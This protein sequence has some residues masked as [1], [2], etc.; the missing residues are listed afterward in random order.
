MRLKME[1]PQAA[2]RSLYQ[3]LAIGWIILSMTVIGFQDARAQLSINSLKITEIIT[4]DYPQ[5]LVRALLRDSNNQPVLTADVP[6]LE[7]IEKVQNKE[8]VY[9]NEAAGYTYQQVSVGVEVIFIVDLHSEMSQ[10]L[11]A[12]GM[13]WMEEARKIVADY[14]TGM[15]AGDTAGILIVDSSGP[16]YLRPITADT[17]ALAGAIAG[18]G[19][20]GISR[21]SGVEAV[22][23][24]LNDLEKSSAYRKV[25]QSVIYISTGPSEQ[26]FILDQVIVRSNELEI[27]VHTFL[28]RDFDYIEAVEPLEKIADGCDGTFTYF[29]NLSAAIPVYNWLSNQRSQTE[30]RYRSSFGELSERTVELRVPNGPSS[31]AKSYL[32]DLQPPLVIIDSPTNNSEFTRQAPRHDSVMDEVLPT[33]QQITAHVEWPDQHPRELVLAQFLLNGVPTDAS[34]SYPSG[35]LIFSWDLK[36]YRTRGNNDVTIQV[37]VQDE[38]GF[39]A[40]SQAV[41]AR[42]TVIIPDPPEAVQPIQG[43][44]IA[45][46]ACANLE[47]FALFWCQFTAQL[48]LMLTTP[49]GWISLGSMIVALAAIVLALRYREPILKAGGEAMDVIRTTF[50]GFGRHEG[51]QATG[52]IEVLRG[53]ADLVGKTIP[54]YPDTLTPI[55][56]SPQEAELVFDSHNERSVVSRRHCE[57]REED[58]VFRIRD[59]GSRH[60]TFVNSNR[61]EEGGDGLILRD[62]DKIELGPA[63]R[64][65][66]LLIFRTSPEKS[67]PPT[68]I[69]QPPPPEPEDDEDGFKTTPYYG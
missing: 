56:R 43:E 17:A 36:P 33:L 8:V 13:T 5:V 15:Q 4:T 6:Q 21:P 34:L 29:N 31:E 46:E 7:I 32:V 69:R 42:V 25:V 16:T 40:D 61:L 35:T 41:S 9:R 38:L 12:T 19:T 68:E 20:N 57:L 1:K 26:S 62:G 52:F 59:A 50:A 24:A 58:G 37:R 63:E 64:G 48:R 45:A 65:G 44:T 14:I 2:M 53:D 60:G 28:V 47:G 23:S 49:S 11:G 66:V 67:L 3:A 22:L 39:I 51:M 55:G 18:I 30:F 10:R 54:L 27:P